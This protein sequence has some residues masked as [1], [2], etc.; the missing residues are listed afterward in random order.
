SELSDLFYIDTRGVLPYASWVE[1]NPTD[2]WGFN[3]APAG[4]DPVFAEALLRLDAGLD[5]L[6]RPDRF[7][8]S[9]ADLPTTW[10]SESAGVLSFS[11]AALAGPGAEPNPLAELE[12]FKD[13][14]ERPRSFTLRLEPVAA[15]T[16]LLERNTGSGWEGVSQA[17]NLELALAQVGSVD[18]YRA[19]LPSGLRLRTAGLSSADLRATALIELPNARSLLGLEAA[20]ALEL[21]HAT[22]TNAG[23]QG[24]VPLRTVEIT[25][26]AAGSLQLQGEQLLDFLLAGNPIGSTVDAIEDAI[27]AVGEAL[28]EALCGLDEGA[29]SPANWLAM[30][31]GLADRIE[32]LRDALVGNLGGDPLINGLAESLGFSFEDLG[33]GFTTV[34][35]TVR[36]FTDNIL[37]PDE[38][39]NRFNQAMDEAG[40]GEISL[41]LVE[42]ASP[43]AFAGECPEHDPAVR[44]PLLYL[45]ELN[46]GDGLDWSIGEQDDSLIQLINDLADI[47]IPTGALDIKADWSVGIDVDAKIGFGFDLD[48]RSVGEFLVLDTAPGAIPFSLP[49]GLDPSAFDELNAS[50]TELFAKAWLDISDLQVSLAGLSARSAPGESLLQAS[51]AAGLDLQV[52]G[53]NGTSYLRPELVDIGQAISGGA[54]TVASGFDA[55]VQFQPEL[56]LDLA[57]QLGDAALELLE[58]FEEAF[59]EGAQSLEDVGDALNCGSFGL[60]QVL[61]ILAQLEQTIDNVQHAIEA[62][63]ADNPLMATF[64]PDIAADIKQ[65]S[66]HFDTAEQALADLRGLGEQIL[67]WNLIPRIDAILPEFLSLE[68][69][70]RPIF[71][72]YFCV[73]NLKPGNIKQI[74]LD[75]SARYSNATGG[76]WINY[77]LP[78]EFDLEGQD[79]T[80]HIFLEASDSIRLP[81]GPDGYRLV[82][83]SG[84][85]SSNA[86]I[87]FAAPFTILQRRDASGH[88]HLLILEGL[89]GSNPLAGGKV[90]NSD[91]SAPRAYSGANVVTQLGNFERLGSSA[92][93]RRLALKDYLS[94]VRSDPNRR[95][96]LAPDYYRFYLALEGLSTTID[97]DFN[98]SLGDIL[99]LSGGFDLNLFAEGSIGFAFDA[100]APDLGSSFL[101]DSAAGVDQNLSSRMPADMARLFGSS[102][103]GS[104]ELVVGATL[105]STEPLRGRL[106]FLELEATSASANVLGIGSAVQGGNPTLP[107]NQDPFLSGALLLGID[108]KGPGT[109]L[110]P[111]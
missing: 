74:R 12:V 103:D 32:A 77:V 46:F 64:A 106:G 47:N 20:A 11:L 16:Y 45:F 85:G 62:G 87:D 56:L 61:F 96:E 15:S 82:D 92:E 107:A 72:S 55:D 10:V 42:S 37:P 59:E 3:T 27:D 79:R 109:G 100:N 83:P 50:G 110:V 14:G 54:L 84:E 1:R 5:R 23:D 2:L 33:A 13:G 57:E 53:S 93:A 34:A 29:L 24:L 90:R 101:L 35:N 44:T 78:A 102:T 7:K 22:L 76:P 8:L 80:T 89:N 30:L 111:L 31:T 26:H 94:D 60:Q 21:Y 91:G 105:Q 4:Y 88:E 18:V 39:A 38:W 68:L 9:S 17:V 86:A 28:D 81:D 40:L 71:D 108:L 6:Q 41:T 67:P 104:P 48:A 36:S 58:P 99:E 97:L 51:I 43:D 63:V 73:T 65:F 52:Q 66:G 69:R 75:S 49:A 25:A 70:S 19:P 95:G 98:T